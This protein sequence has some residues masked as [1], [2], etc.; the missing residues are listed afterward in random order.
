MVTTRSE[1]RAA[2]IRSL[3]SH[4]AT[5]ERYL[6][7]RVGGNFR[8]DALQ[9]AILSVKLDALPGWTRRRRGLAARYHD[10]LRAPAER[11]HLVLPSEPS[12]GT[13]E[14]PAHVY[15]QFVIRADR[16]D[17][18]KRW[19]AERGVATGIYYPVPLHLQPCF[20][21]LG[22]AEGDFPEAERACREVLALPIFPELSDDQQSRVAEAIRAFYGG[23]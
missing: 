3:R 11:G 9:A 23:D 8:I 5:T 14:R 2:S 20:A 18:L 10:L 15:H 16:R 1:E 4:G 19:L 12:W 21:H 13:D 7:H 17:D 6:H 22:Y